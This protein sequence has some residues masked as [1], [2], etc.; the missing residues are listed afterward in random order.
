MEIVIVTVSPAPAWV[1]L[2]GVWRATLSLSAT[3]EKTLSGAST[4]VSPAS[5]SA[6][7]ASATES[8]TTSGTSTGAPLLTTIDTT[9]SGERF[10]PAGGSVEITAPLGT[11]SV[12]SCVTVPG[13][14]AA[15]LICCCATASVLPVTSGTWTSC[16]P[17]DT[18]SVTSALLR[19]RRPGPGSVEITWPRGT[20]RLKPVVTLV[21]SPAWSSFCCA[22]AC[23]SARTAGTLVNWPSLMYQTPAPTP[24]ISSAATITASTPRR[25]PRRGGRC[26]AGPDGPGGPAGT[27]GSGG[28]SCRTLVRLSS[29]SAGR[30]GR[31]MTL[32]CSSS[33]GAP[34]KS[35]CQPVPGTASCG[36]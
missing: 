31:E 24:R 29:S 6:C 5:C 21:C 1:P 11:S 3:S 32:V 12:N 14:S 23:D 35:F 33:P 36:S 30:T 17:L 27:G 4:T 28:G 20:V 34:W 2:P 19:T 7:W 22:S 10:V 16:G 13:V 26:P 25:G 8:P 18:V 9:A 15:P